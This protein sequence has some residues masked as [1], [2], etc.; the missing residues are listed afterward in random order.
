MQS[1]LKP[2]VCVLVFMACSFAGAVEQPILYVLSVGVDAHALKEG[3]KDDYGHDAKVMQK[4][5]K[6]KCAPLF[7]EI[8][9]KLLTGENANK[10]NIIK[11]L[12]WLKNNVGTNDVAF[13]LISAHGAM[14]KKN[15]FWI[16]NAGRDLKNHKDTTLFGNDIKKMMGEISGRVYFYLDTCAAGAILIT[17]PNNPIPPNVYIVC[18]CQAKEEA[19]TM[20]TKRNWSV[21]SKAMAEGMLGKADF[22]H[23]GTVTLG[24]LE[25]YIKMRTPQLNGGQHP[26]FAKPKWNYSVPL[27]KP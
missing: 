7:K 27:T 2:A 18:A 12:T 13:V 11:G 5:L 21:L 3:K 1:F 16:E 23:D 22:N 20:G 25:A 26:A 10:E 4:V 14:G 8:H 6:E 9:S 15:G 24:E 17:T 19:A